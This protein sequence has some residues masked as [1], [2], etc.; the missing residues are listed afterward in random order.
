MK[1]QDTSKYKYERIKKFTANK[2][3][4]YV[5]ISY[6]TNKEDIFTSRVNCDLLVKSMLRS[7]F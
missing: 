2:A 6:K 7:T 3:T 4:K 1:T 5:I